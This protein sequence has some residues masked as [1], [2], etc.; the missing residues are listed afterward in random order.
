M[1]IDEK[2]IEKKKEQRR[3]EPVPELSRRRTGSFGSA[4]GLWGLGFLL[5]WKRGMLVRRNRNC[6]RQEKPPRGQQP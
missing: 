1:G 5:D 6:E 3:P 2:E 4:F